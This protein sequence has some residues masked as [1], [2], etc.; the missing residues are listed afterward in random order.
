MQPPHTIP[1]FSEFLQLKHQNPS[2]YWSKTTQ[3]QMHKAYKH[4]G[5]A[6]YDHYTQAKP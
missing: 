2:A 6:F 5:P 3:A 4:H 1:Y